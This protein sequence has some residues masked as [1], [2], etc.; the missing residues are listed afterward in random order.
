MVKI[1]Y[2][3]SGYLGIVQLQVG[4][5]SFELRVAVAESCSC[6][7]QVAGWG[8]EIQVPPFLGPK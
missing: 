7:F 5:A 4:V 2:N 3:G 1:H 6:E 8:L